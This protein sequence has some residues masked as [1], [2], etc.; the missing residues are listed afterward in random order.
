[1]AMND[2]T[3]SRWNDFYAAVSA[4]KTVDNCGMEMDEEEKMIF[5]SLVNTRK[6]Y[7][8]ENP[9]IPFE[10]EPVEKETEF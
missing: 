4:G 5:N 1:M 10:F 8:E 9:G 3:A 7:M 6:K 2:M